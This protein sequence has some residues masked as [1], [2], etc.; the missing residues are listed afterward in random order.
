MR[1]Y[2]T[3][4]ISLVI[5]VMVVLILAGCSR[6]GGANSNPASQPSV[7]SEIMATAEPTLNSGLDTLDSQLNDLQKTLESQDTVDDFK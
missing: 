6:I 1:Y 4:W 2:K 5:G 3:L 7:G